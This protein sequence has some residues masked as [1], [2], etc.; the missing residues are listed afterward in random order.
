MIAAGAE[1]MVRFKVAVES[2]PATLVVL[3]T[4]VPLVLYV[5]PFQV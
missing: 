1:L 4:Y 2:Q 3:K 5:L